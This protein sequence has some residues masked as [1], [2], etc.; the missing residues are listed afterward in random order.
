MCCLDRLARATAAVTFPH[1]KPGEQ[2]TYC[3]SGNSPTQLLHWDEACHRH[4]LNHLHA[5]WISQSR[6]QSEAMPSMGK[7]LGRREGDGVFFR[8]FMQLRFV[9]LLNAPFSRGELAQ[10]VRQLPCM[11]T[12]CCC[13]SPGSNGL[14]HLQ[15]CT[16]AY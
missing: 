1:C 15:Q 6:T 16:E 10:V 5:C 12:D 9:R 14:P 13:C 8:A 4:S 7:R 3:P 2:D 11:R